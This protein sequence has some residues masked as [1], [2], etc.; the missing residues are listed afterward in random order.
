MKGKPKIPA[1]PQARSVTSNRKK[2]DQL[3]ERKYRKQ[4]KHRVDKF[5]EELRRYRAQAIKER[6]VRMDRSK[7]FSYGT[8]VFGDRSPDDSAHPYHYHD[9]PFTCRDCGKEEVWTGIQQKWWHEVIG[10]DIERKASRCRPC[11][12]KERTRKEEARRR[13]LEGMERKRRRREGKA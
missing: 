11:R 3:A 2:R 1:F 8:K 12:I 13:M 7:I 10:G 4:S 6:W 5:A 9:I